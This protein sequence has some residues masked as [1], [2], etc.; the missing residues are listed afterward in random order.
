VTAGIE[1]AEHGQDATLD[2]TGI[3]E[4]QLRSACIV[5]AGQALD[6]AG[7]DWEAA[8]G[9][10]PDAL[11]GVGAIPYEAA[12]RGPYGRRPPQKGGYA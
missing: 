4:A 10:L 2:G 8:K 5:L 11:R 9:L 6:A 7:G 3:T 1:F 12:S